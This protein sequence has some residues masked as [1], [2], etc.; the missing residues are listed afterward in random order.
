MVCCIESGGLRA[1]SWVLGTAGI[2]SLSVVLRLVWIRMV[3]VIALVYS[4]EC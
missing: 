2:Q 1:R 4:R 3:L